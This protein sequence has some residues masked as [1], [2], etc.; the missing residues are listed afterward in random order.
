MRL[1]RSTPNR[2]STS[3]GSGSEQVQWLLGS[4]NQQG[5]MWEQQNFYLIRGL[6]KYGFNEEADALKAKTLAVVWVPVSAGSFPGRGISAAPGLRVVP[7]TGVFRRVHG[8]G[9]IFR[10][11]ATPGVIFGQKGTLCDNF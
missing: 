10:Y 9:V 6:R 11:S 5:P 1:A 2:S 7:L 8:P 4:S 3:D